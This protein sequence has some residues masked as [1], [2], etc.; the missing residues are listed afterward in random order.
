MPQKDSTARV[1]IPVD[2]GSELLGEVMSLGRVNAKTLGYFPDGAFEDYASRGQVLACTEDGGLCGYLV[3]RTSEVTITLVHLCV[4]EGLRERGIAKA[5]LD[6][7]AERFPGFAGILARCRIDFPANDIWPSLGFTLRNEVP[8]RAIR[9]A[10]TLRVWWRDFGLPDLFST[11]PSSRIVVALDTNVLIDL[12]ADPSEPKHV[13]SRALLADWLGDSIEYVLT[14]EVFAEIARHPDANTR[15]NRQGYASRFRCLTDTDHEITRELTH[16]LGE[17]I[18]V[19]ESAQDKSDRRHL[20]LS[21]LGGASFFVTKDAGLLAAASH[22]N[23]CIGLDVTR[24]ADFIA[25]T[26]ADLTEQSFAPIRLSGSTLSTRPYTDADIGDLLQT[27]QAFDRGE[28]RSELLGI[29][30]NALAQPQHYDGRIVT[31]HDA[32]SLGF[33]LLRF[34]DDE[35]RIQLLRTTRGSLSD[36]LARHLMWLAVRRAR[37]EACPVIRLTDSHAAPATEGVLGVLGFRPAARDMAKVNGLGVMSTH[38]LTDFLRAVDPGFTDPTWVEDTVRVLRREQSELPNQFAFACERLVW[39]AK[40]LNTALPSFIV[41]I[42]PEWAMQL[43]HAR[44]AGETLFGS[45]PSL[46]LRLNNVYYRS[47]RPR[48]IEA[49]ARILW[50]VTASRER[51]STRCV[52]A[53]SLVE[54]VVRGPAKEVFSRFKRYGVFEW[55]HVRRLAN[56]DP[57]GIVEVLRF[58]HTEQFERPVDLARIREL[59]GQA[60]VQMPVLQSPSRVPTDLFSA[61]YREGFP[62]NA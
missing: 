54:E 61:I 52:A 50:Y 56:N 59:A 13:E 20:V 47:S 41:P 3:F 5:L 62:A 39:A 48:R 33:L 18:G 11:A 21:T 55:V 6:H 16:H 17:V 26:H 37:Q 8:G 49:P 29:L 45:D 57:Y 35:A 10:S 14:E 58:G 60:G 38:S 28:R 43:F 27:F 19:G 24:P 1:I 12:Q 34:D 7:L 51:P 23:R 42:Q 40:L 30:R 46:M 31:G 32:P 22:I 36:V 4:A 9:Q 15:K 25:R 2:S 53:T 44:L